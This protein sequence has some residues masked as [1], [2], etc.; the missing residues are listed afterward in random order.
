MPKYKRRKKAPATEAWKLVK[1]EH[2]RAL[3]RTNGF[4]KRRAFTPDVKLEDTKHVQL[5]V[6][7]RFCLEPVPIVV[8]MHKERF[9]VLDVQEGS[10]HQLKK[11]P[12]SLIGKLLKPAF[13]ALSHNQRV[14]KVKL[15]KNM[16][17]LGECLIFSGKAVKPH[18]T[19]YIK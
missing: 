13:N 12:T 15:V 19:F 8:V 16:A 5:F 18:A 11:S 1:R 2:R 17:S 14:Y 4:R 10:T 6:D 9:D 7:E 3:K